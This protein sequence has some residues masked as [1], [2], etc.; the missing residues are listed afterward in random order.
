M[1]MT[2]LMIIIDYRTIIT[3]FEL[4]EIECINVVDWGKSGLFGAVYEQMQEN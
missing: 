4:V 1:I 3:D 2:W